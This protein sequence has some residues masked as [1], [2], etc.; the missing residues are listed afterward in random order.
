MVE[1]DGTLDGGSFPWLALSDESGHQ[2]KKGL[3]C[4]TVVCNFGVFALALG[5]KTAMFDSLMP[6]RSRVLLGHYISNYQHSS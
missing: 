2:K 3:D 6:R 1:T 4:L 5:K